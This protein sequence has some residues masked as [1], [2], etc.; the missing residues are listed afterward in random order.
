[1]RVLQ[2]LHRPQ[3]RGAELFAAELSGELARRGH[4]VASAYLYP[5]SGAAAARLPLGDGDVVL[6]GREDHPLETTLGFHP[7]LVARLAAAVDG[8]RPDV[9]QVNGSRTVKYGA[10]VARRR[11][12]RDWV[13]VY[14]NIGD[15]RHWLRGGARRLFYRRV[16][17]PRIDGVVSVSRATAEAVA[18]VYGS[19]VPV[20]RLPRAVD[21]R[22]LAPRRA[23]AAVRTAVGT[24]DGRTVVLFLGSLAGEKRLDLLIGAIARLVARG[25]EVELWLV[26]DGPLAGQADRWA[27]QR[28]VADRVRRAGATDDPGSFLAAADLLALASDTE[29]VPG[30]VV[31]AAWMGRPAV[32]TR[33]GGVEEVIADGVDG[34]LVPAGDEAALAAALDT[35]VVDAELRRRLGEAARARA[36]RDHA[37]P[38][39]AERLVGFYERLLAARREG[40]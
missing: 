37:L 4:V 39:A 21:P 38:V 33:V 14:R 29:G 30:V 13:L 8:F 24:P 40:G 12:H 3:R 1:M 16:V 11:P 15:P 7:R 2:V 22:R 19:R 36:E 27:A 18:A 35:L 17:M 5:A 31:E 26:G 28:G 25:R 10:L 6:G 9:V 20:L 32:A 34:L 23:A